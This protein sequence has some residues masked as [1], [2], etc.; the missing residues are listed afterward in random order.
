[1]AM[2]RTRPDVVV[3]GAGPVGVVLA[4]ELGRRGVRT[5]LVDPELGRD[6]NPRCNTISARTMELLRHLGLSHQVRELGLPADH[7]T[8]VVHMTR[9][10]GHEI[11]RLPL[12]A[13]ADASRP[14]GFFGSWPSPEPVHRLSQSFMHPV[15][16]DAL[17][18]CPSVVTMSSHR[19]ESFSPTGDAVR[20]ELLDDSGQA[21]EVSTDYLV[22]CDG[23][24]S[25]VRR[26]LGVP[27]R[28]TDAPLSQHLSVYFR[29]R[30][31][32]AALA[33]RPAWKID[34]YSSGF[35]GGLVAIDGVE[36][37]VYH[38]TVPLGLPR[39]EQPDPVDLVRHVFGGEL[40]L[41]VVRAE[42]WSARRLVAERFADGRVFL[43]GDAAH[44]WMPVGG[45]GMNTG[46]ADA[47]N[48]AWKLA[49]MIQRWGG[50]LLLDSY[51][52]ERRPVAVLTGQAVEDWARTRLRVLDAVDRD[53]LDDAARGPEER[54]RLE[55][56]LRETEFRKWRAFGIEFGYTYADSA[57]VIDDGTTVPDGAD[58]VQD[59]DDCLRSGARLPHR[60]LVDERSTHD[61]VGLGLGLI[62]AQ[63]DEAAADGFAEEARGRRVPL[64]LALLAPVDADALGLAPG[65]AVL[66]RPDLHVAWSGRLAETDAGM[67]IDRVRGLRP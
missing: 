16:I 12:P 4:L 67:V 66:V 6:I 41:D 44:A 1:M 17:A 63:A 39:S 18:D 20:C 35:E 11:A 28:G 22:G 43:A 49:A 10:G 60:W 42:S 31:L 24:R 34:Y 36:R 55:A 54:R 64:D 48:L 57:I 51:S 13:R 38:A 19:L 15:L 25:G 33:D 26:A 3:A 50:P 47:V 21:L 56:L 23:A 7:A 37:F 14:G 61:L 5:L 52:A 32:G 62:T 65:A 46:V 58:P 2:M 45:F 59:Y 8:D 9:P 27:L 30:G 53:A 29:S 40:D